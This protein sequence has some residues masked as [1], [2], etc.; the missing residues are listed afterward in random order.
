MSIISSSIVLPSTVSFVLHFE[1]MF[2]LVVCLVVCLVN[3]PVVCHV[4]F[5]SCCFCAICNVVQLIICL[6]IFIVICYI[7]SL[8]IPL[9]NQLVCF[10]IRPGFCLTY[11]ENR[12]S[13][14]LSCFQNVGVAMKRNIPKLLPCFAMI[15]QLLGPAATNSC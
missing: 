6:H 2:C 9:L 15:S 4:V 5:L 14:C 1:T 3:Y 8:V 13:Y 12:P 11:L 7:V 10:I